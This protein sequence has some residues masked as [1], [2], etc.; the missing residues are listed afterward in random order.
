VGALV[1]L[2]LA[3]LAAPAAAQVQ[4]AQPGDPDQ[5]LRAMR[6]EMARS[7]ERLRIAELERPYYIEYRLLDVDVRAVTASFGALVTSTATRNRFMAVDVRVGDYQLD[8]SNFYG[9]D[10]F[11]GFIGSTGTVGIDR[12]YDSLRQDLWLATDQAYKEALDRLARKRGYLRS[13]A[14]PPD[15]PDFSR[16]EPV[17]L[18]GPRVEPDWTSRDWEAEARL[19]SAAFRGY[20]E[21]YS[22]RV[23]YYLVTMTSYLMT[24]EG[25][26]V[27]TGR[28]LA[29]IEAGADTQTDDGMRLHNFYTAYVPRPQD[30]PAAADVR[31][32]LERVGRE[33][34]M[35]RASPP[36]QDY[37]GPVLLEAP[38][39]GAL[40]VQLV[41]PS[42]AGARPPLSVLP[43]FD[44]MLERLGVRSEWTGRLGT[45]VFPTSV[46]LADD[47]TVKEF[48]GTPLLGHYEVDDEGV[49]A[50]RVQ[51]VEGGALRGLVMSR[52]PGPDFQR[53]NGHAR[54]S[55]IG[56]P[57]PTL[58][59]LFFEAS[60][61]VPPAEL[62][63]RF[64]EACRA[65]GREWCLIV[66]RMDNPV[67]GVHRQEDAA[68][69]FAGLASGAATGDRLP[70]IVY[71]F[72]VK[73]ERME[74]VRGARLAGVT[75]R[76]LRNLAGI[77]NDPAVSHFMLSLTPGFGSV[78]LGSAQG[79]LPGS[80]VAPSLLLED[81]EVRG[82]RGE[83]RRPPLLPPPPL[84]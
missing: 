57:R 81:V 65:E 6:D 14:R 68:E 84:N 4:R 62:R 31:K 49:R 30:L 75:L 70:L 7:R 50:Q 34:V 64:V 55:L 79:G 1:V 74:L 41:A 63:K 53:S 28:T 12:D 69:M 5:T 47:P 22:S 37:V 16:E 54:A 24:S 32:E 11:R 15:I 21:L 77:G 10:L 46:S 44:Q 3:A 83:P 25:T 78:A 38:A 20:P 33:L 35:M 52:R 45:R 17:V 26:Q 59:N 56:D 71:R 39:S 66:R 40:L 48:A 9:E 27:R 61:A 23:V 29:A 18:I 60:G 82:A 76:T 36:A 43:F 67:L 58:A 2:L 73:D 19:T 8:S 72:Y 80:V 13:L 51:L 42:A